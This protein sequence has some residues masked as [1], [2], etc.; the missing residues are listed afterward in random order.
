M[1]LGIASALDDNHEKIMPTIL[2]GISISTLINGFLFM[3]VGY[4]KIGKILHICPRYVFLGMG[5][6]FGFFIVLQAFEIA[7]TMPLSQ[8]ALNPL[9]ANMYVTILFVVLLF[10]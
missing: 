7:T 1:S 10:L 6:G 3:L 9:N 4:L 2:F 5:V 8:A